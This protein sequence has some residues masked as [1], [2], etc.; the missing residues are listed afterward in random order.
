MKKTILLLAAMLP[1]FLLFSQTE[2]KLRQSWIKTAVENL[3]DRP[4]EPD[5]L[6]TRYTFDG[7][8]LYIGF[9]PAW[10]DYQQ[11]W[12]VSGSYLIIGLSTYMIEELTDTSLIIAEKGS[13]RMKFLS[14]DYLSNREEYLI[15]AGEYQGKPLYK[16]NYY[17]TARYSKKTSLQEFIY[18]ARSKYDIRRAA[19]FL[20]TFIITEEGKLENI[21]VVSSISPDFDNDIVKQLSKTSKNWDPAYFKGMPIQTKMYYDIKF[22]Q[23][24][25]LN[26][27]RVLN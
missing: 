26:G 23:P 10:N 24:L 22:L 27:R 2:K 5:T 11:E 20:V 7:S 15:P 21:Q 13:R 8:T 18:K 25:Q 19:Y 1:A 3:S 14:A 6:F 12:I 9:N 17:I 16:A 4:V